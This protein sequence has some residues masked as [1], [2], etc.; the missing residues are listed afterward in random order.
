MARAEAERAGRR[1][2][3]EIDIPRRLRIPPRPRLELVLVPVGFGVGLL[4]SLLVLAGA[5]EKA[6]TVQAA[7]PSLQPSADHGRKG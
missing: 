5:G 1:Q 2:A 4:I 7:Q 6:G 3:A